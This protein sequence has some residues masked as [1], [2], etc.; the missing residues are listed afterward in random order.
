MIDKHIKHLP[1]YT[2]THAHTLYVGTPYAN[3]IRGQTTLRGQTTH[4]HTHGGWDAH[5]PTHTHTHTHHHTHHHRHTHTNN[6]IL[7][8]RG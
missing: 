7:I 5:S 4:T 3:P 6:F 8:T 2:R 1:T